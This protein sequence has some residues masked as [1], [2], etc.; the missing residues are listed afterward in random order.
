MPSH[1]LDDDVPVHGFTVICHAGNDF[2]SVFDCRVE[3]DGVVA[4]SDISVER[5]GNPEEFHIR[6]FLVELVGLTVGSVSAEDE[7]SVQTQGIV[8][9]IADFGVV[10]AFVIED[11]Y[12][13]AGAQASSSNFEGNA[14]GSSHGYVDGVVPDKTGPAVFETNEFR[15][16]C[17]GI[18]AKIFQGGIHPCSGTATKDYTKP[19]FLIIHCHKVLS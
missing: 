17:P 2:S 10:V 13:R 6:I 11:V 9:L 19:F 14:A 7:D 1:A 12:L 3:T 16:F 4:S 8:G 15:A 18:S 5:G